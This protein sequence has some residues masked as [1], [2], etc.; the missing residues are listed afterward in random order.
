[1]NALNPAPESEIGNDLGGDPADSAK[2]AWLFGQV[3]PGQSQSFKD[4]IG[5]SYSFRR[6]P[7]DAPPSPTTSK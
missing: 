2:V 7:H 4:E 3:A 1:M 5:S 6:D